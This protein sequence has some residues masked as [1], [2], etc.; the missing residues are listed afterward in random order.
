MYNEFA[1][2][3]KLLVIIKKMDG[4]QW[5]L[6]PDALQH[7]SQLHTHYTYWVAQTQFLQQ[8]QQDAFSWFQ[9]LNS[10]FLVS[11]LYCLLH[12]DILRK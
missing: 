2:I 6:F 7:L 10:D 1:A 8:T 4:L 11:S 3:Q 5:F 12:S 9:S